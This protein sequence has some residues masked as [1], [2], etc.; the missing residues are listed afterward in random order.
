MKRF[1]VETML[2]CS[3][4]PGENMTPNPPIIEPSI[5]LN[6]KRETTSGGAR[7]TQLRLRRSK[8]ELLR[9][10]PHDHLVYHTCPPSLTATG[11]SPLPS[12][13]VAL[14][15]GK[16]KGLGLASNLFS[17]F[18]GSASQSETYSSSSRVAFTSSP[19]PLTAPL[20]FLL[21]RTA[22]ARS[23]RTAMVLSQ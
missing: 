22:A 20:T 17:L 19:L 13:H 6:P 15:P 21:S 12:T 7:P 23:S 1:S 8:A 9:I 14:C 18:V 2:K 11:T 3:N 16:C 4:R 5:F 10:V